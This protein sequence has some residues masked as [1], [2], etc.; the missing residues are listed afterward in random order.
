MPLSKIWLSKTLAEATGNENTESKNE[1][2][3]KYIFTLI[4]FRR[5][6]NRIFSFLGVLGFWGFGVLG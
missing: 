6:K 2:N 4:N 3:E 1:F 5:K